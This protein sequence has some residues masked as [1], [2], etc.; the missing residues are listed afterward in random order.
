MPDHA[1]SNHGRLGRSRSINGG[2]ADS[3]RADGSKMRDCN[4]GSKSGA[5]QGRPAG[6]QYS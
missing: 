5:P 3:D 6:M 2:A 4:A 1:F